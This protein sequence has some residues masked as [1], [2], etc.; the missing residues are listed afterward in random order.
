MS[1]PKGKSSPLIC[2]KLL[3][4]S[5]RLDETDMRTRLTNAG[6]NCY[7]RNEYEIACRCV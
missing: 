2:P 4:G 5:S 6:K 3:E 7:E 1:T